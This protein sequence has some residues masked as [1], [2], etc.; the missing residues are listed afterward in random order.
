MCG[1]WL[2]YILPENLKGGG[3]GVG[4]TTKYANFF[5]RI[6]FPLFVLQIRSSNLSHRCEET[7]IYSMS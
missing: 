4:L 7:P 6:E 1:L 5:Y 3:G 2:Y